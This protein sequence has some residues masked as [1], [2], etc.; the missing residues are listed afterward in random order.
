MIKIDINNLDYEKLGLMCG[1]ELHQQ[2]NTNKLFCNCPSKLINDDLKPDKV[3]HRQLR[4]VSSE[5]GDLDVTAK[6]EQDKNKIFKYLFYNSCNCLVETDSQPPLNINKD[7]LNI[8]LVV[9]FLTNS[10]VVNTSHVMRK[11]VIN[12]SN[13]SGFQRTTMISTDGYL[14]FSFG[15]VRIDKILLEEDAART[16]EKTDSIVTYSLDRLGIPLIELVA[17]HDMHT[18]E[19]VKEVALYLGQMFR[20]TGK[21]KRG[22]G[23]IRQDINI[24]IKDGS[25]VE[26]K[27]CQ[28]LDLIPEIVNREIVRQLNLIDIKKEVIEK[29]LT[30]FSLKPIM[31]NDYFKQTDSKVVLK[32]FSENKN[33]YLFLLPGFKGF[34]GREIQPNR[35][36]GTEIAS[37]L[38]MRTTLKGLFHLDELPNYGITEKEVNLIKKD[39]SVK[40]NDSFIIIFSSENEISS[41][42]NVIEDRLNKLKDGVLKE[43]RASTVEGNTEYQRPLSTSSRMYPETDLSPIVFNEELLALAK[44][45]VPLSLEDRK[46]LY[47]DTFKLSSQL[48]DKMKLNNFAPI[49][50]KIVSE[51]KINPT[52]L[53]VFL[54]ED[55]IKASREGVLDLD[56]VNDSLL[57][58]FFKTK[59]LF[60]RINKNKLLDVFIEFLK[61]PLDLERIIQ[62]NK[63]EDLSFDVLTNIIDQVIDENK[64]F[65][66]KQKERSLGLLMGRVMSKTENKYDGKIISQ[67]IKERLNLF[68]KN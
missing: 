68:L 46:K 23:S 34:L 49:F 26:I 33:A 37:V 51:Y 66:L 15:K 35:R 63:K 28:D 8:A 42:K 12:G 21:T 4:A 6:E 22:L 41:V 53:S 3:I 10:V 2:L 61:N 45:E 24:S 30:S 7:A 60:N 43:T 17:W 65:I 48:A 55:L 44:K 11:Q 13:V 1:L 40:E 47:V 67:T 57:I 62:E 25:R 59:D 38:K 19:Q 32:S 14:D 16:I 31:I 64:D 50:E 56:D 5:T 36:L 18:P 54:L 58:N 27:G 29:N 52:T 9:S 39:F 20:S